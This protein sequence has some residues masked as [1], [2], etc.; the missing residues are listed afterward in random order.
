MR[1]KNKIWNPESD[2]NPVIEVSF[3]RKPK[4]LELYFRIEK[5]C[6]FID[7]SGWLKEAAM[8]KLEREENP[9]EYNKNYSY[10]PVLN[11]NLPINENG[12]DTL[13]GVFE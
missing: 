4:E 10:R 12:I 5:R 1:N 13:L 2:R 8:E 3:K 9:H 7:V 6:N 11:N